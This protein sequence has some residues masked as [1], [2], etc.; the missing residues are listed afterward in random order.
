MKKCFQV[1]FCVVYSFTNKLTHQIPLSQVSEGLNSP[2]FVSTIFTKSL[3]VPTN[4]TQPT[5]TT[6]VNAKRTRKTTTTTT[7]K[8][9]TVPEE[10]RRSLVKEY[11]PYTFN[12]I[13]EEFYEWFYKVL[14]DNKRKEERFKKGRQLKTTF[15]DYPR[16]LQSTPFPIPEIHRPWYIYVTEIER[17]Y[18]ITTNLF[19]TGPVE[20]EWFENTVKWPPTKLR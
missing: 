19:Y 17:L 9:Y 2:K 16:L 5:N 13:Y 12:S 1:F 6:K 4:K 14:T 7:C 20:Q 15:I 10:R 3:N 8:P 11:F 18:N